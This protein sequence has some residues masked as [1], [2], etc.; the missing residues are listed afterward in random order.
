[1]AKY[2]VNYKCGHSAWVDLFGKETERMSKIKW[3]ETTLCPDCYEAQKH[4]DCDIVEMKYSEYKKS[5]ANNGTV[6][7]SYNAATKTIKVYVKKA[8]QEPAKPDKANM[9]KSEIFKAAH[10]MA[11]A[12]KQK[13]PGIDY[14]A[15]F[16]A[17]L[18]AMLEDIKKAKMTKAAA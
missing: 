5:Y 16:G 11:K 15:Q 12:A 7:G 3:L 17:I 14:R 18:K 10:K 13:W 8:G 9:T 6:N 4:A 1:M 2:N